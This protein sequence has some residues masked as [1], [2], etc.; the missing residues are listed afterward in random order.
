MPRKPV[1]SPTRIRTYLDCV[2]KYRY[3][4]VDGLARFY[5]R[6]RAE[7]SFGSTLHRVLQAFYKEGGDGSA[8][9]LV[10][11]LDACWVSAGYETAEQE[12][13]FRRTAEQILREYHAEARRRAGLDIET[14][15]LEQTVRA[16]LGRFLLGGRVDRIDRH[17]D[18]LLEIVDYKSGRGDVTAE[19]VAGDL[20]M[21]SYQLAVRMANPGTRVAST[22]YCLRTGVAASAEMAEE[23]AAGFA[24]E[25]TALGEEIIDRDLDG[26]EPEPV[27]AC[28]R[29]DFRPRCERYWAGRL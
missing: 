5:G 6:P 24:A 8:E 27:E 28:A 13:E 7:F 3:T 21:R 18:G 29:C 12:D 25:I 11:R 17:P 16:D 2:V 10:A 9:G 14:I 20:A 26:V 15:A 1:L 19:E 23:E 4:Y 22:I